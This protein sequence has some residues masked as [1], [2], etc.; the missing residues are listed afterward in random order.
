MTTVGIRELKAHLSE[1]LQKV[2][3]GE[4]VLI[5]ERGKVVAR[6]TPQ[7][8]G[9]DDGRMEKVR[10]MVDEGLAAWNFRPFRPEPPANN[11]LGASLSDLVLT[12][13][14]E[15]AA[16]FDPPSRADR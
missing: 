12:E 1:Y 9:P 4:D 7:P 3:A 8:P 16:R 2:K 5:T 13:R 6:L 11:P 15:Q 10:A 14:E